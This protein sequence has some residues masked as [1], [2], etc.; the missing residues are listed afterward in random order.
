MQAV[1]A[2]QPKTIFNISEL[3][4]GFN[5]NRETVAKRL[6]LAGIAPVE[7]KA[8]ETLYKLDARL[9]EILIAADADIEAERLRKISAEADLKEMQAQQLRGELA[10]VSEFQEIVQALFGGLYKEIAVRFP[11]KVAARCARAKTA[12]E[13]AALLQQQ[14]NGI[15]L[16]IRNDF[17]AFLVKN[18]EK[19]P[20]TAKKS[21]KKAKN[22]K[23]TPVPRRKT[24]A[25]SPK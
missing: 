14:L 5:L 23:R 7:K 25:E 1:A 9:E 2:E 21:P 19:L 4:Q 16:A 17:S 15:F 22:V 12:A 13:A 6:R 10:P 3:A 8:K 18:A 20:E 11:K 24:T